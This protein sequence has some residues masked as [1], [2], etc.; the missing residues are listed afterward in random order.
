MQVVA[1]LQIAVSNYRRVRGA[2]MRVRRHTM[3]G[4]YCSAEQQK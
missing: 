3:T 4:V 2:G 1:Y